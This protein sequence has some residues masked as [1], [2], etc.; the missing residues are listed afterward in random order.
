MKTGATSG[1]GHRSRW[2]GRR[3]GSRAGTLASKVTLAR[4]GAF[5][6]ALALVLALAACAQNPVTGRNELLLV[7][8]EW[9]LSVGRQQYAPLRQSQGG[10]YVVDPAVEDYVRE[11]GQR[12]AAKSDRRLPYEFNVINDSSPNAWALP[13]GKI[14]INRGLLV[15]LEDEAQL[16]AVLGHEIVH[17]AAKHGARGQTRGIG[18]QLA[19]ITATVIGAREGYGQ[20]AQLGSSVGAQI[21][22]SKYGRDAEL[23]ADRYGM[24]YMSR[25]GY[26]PDAAVELQRTFVRLSEGRNPNWLTGLFASHPPSPARVAAN[27]ETSAALPDG[28]ES[29]R[30][31]YRRAMARLFD[32]REAYETF[33][34]AQKLAADGDRAAAENLAR[35]AIRIEPLE[36]HFHSFLGDLALER[37]DYAEAEGFYDR[38]ISLNDEFFYYWLQRGKANEAQRDARAAQA[39][40]QRSVTLMPTADAQAALGAIAEARGDR[41]TAMR[42]Y[43]A[44]A[45]APGEGG[46]RARAALERI[47][48]ERLDPPEPAARRPGAEPPV[49]PARDRRPPGEASRLVQVRSGLTRQGT[50]A[51]ELVNPT[52][53]PIAEVL[54]AVTLEP[55]ARTR[56]QMVREVLP[57]GGRRVIDTGRR[58]GRTQLERVRVEVVGAEVA[59]RR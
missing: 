24:E 21:V 17:A 57:P 36:G 10:D 19:V 20:L 35:Q 28:G 5:A 25:A 18:L 15:E 1:T 33:D 51:F 13:G 32:R 2:A 44:A 52:S 26:D 53:R 47:A 4:A 27:I 14:G 59:G 41:R 7:S 34:R 8:E 6:G 46:E 45:Q 54:L 39:D 55:G 31:R 3:A 43:V 49:P 56:R 40:Y 29:G 30:E 50:L 23:E 58:I 16:A 48:P 9:E 12:L 38:A 37:R 42:W 22:N 11:V